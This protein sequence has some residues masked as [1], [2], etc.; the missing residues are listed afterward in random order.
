MSIWDRMAKQAITSRNGLY[1]GSNVQVMQQ[2]IDDGSVALIYTDPPF[3]SQAFYGITYKSGSGVLATAQED[4]FTDLFVRN[5]KS[6]AALKRVKNAHA[7]LK[8]MFEAWDGLIPDGTVAYLSY[9]AETMFECHRVLADNGSLYWHCD[10]AAD[11]YTRQLL[12]VLFGHQGFR[13]RIIWPRMI[14]SHNDASARYARETDTILFFTK[15]MNPSWNSPRRAQDEAYVEATYRFSDHRGRFSTN[16]LT[17]ESLSGG[18]YN[19]EWNGHTREWKC[20]RTEMERLHKEDLLVYSK[21]GLPR[22]KYYLSDI[23]DK[24]ARDLWDDIPPL[25]SN[26]QE[27]RGYDTQKPEAMLYRIIGASSNIGDLILDPFAGSG[28]TG[29]VAEALDRRWVLIDIEPQ[30][31]VRIREAFKV[32]FPDKDMTDPNY[33]ESA[34]WPSNESSAHDLATDDPTA[35]EIWFVGEFGA[36]PTGQK[37]NRKEG[38]KDGQLFFFEGDE[39]R[40]IW[41]EVKAGWP[42]RAHFDQFVK[43]IRDDDIPIGI[44]L[45]ENEPPSTW[46]TDAEKEGVYVS[47]NYAIAGVGNEFPRIQ[48]HTLADHFAGRRP[49]YPNAIARANVRP[50]PVQRR[51]GPMFYQPNL[52]AE[53]FGVD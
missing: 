50:H 25:S 33:V 37:N 44:M 3:N 22:R 32:R 11:H 1:Y 20:P 41:F 13:N 51:S 4:A 42:S 7:G 49:Q 48:F 23:K 17:A 27:R 12:E 29:L 28:T 6:N 2:R 34:G 10:S 26:S 30:A 40:T 47:D 18:G 36:E 19:Y 52:I 16:H 38:K 14:G 35:F 46:R 24:V 8:K 43:K 15:G 5:T 53:L 31:I 21:S 39:R 45:M 9:M